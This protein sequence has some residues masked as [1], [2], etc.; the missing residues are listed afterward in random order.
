MVGKKSAK[1][2]ADWERRMKDSLQKMESTVILLEKVQ[3]EK[4]VIERRQEQSLA[5]IKS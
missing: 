1:D 3:Q 4:E 5:E 2:K